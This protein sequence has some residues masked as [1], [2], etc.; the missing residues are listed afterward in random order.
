MLLNNIG[1]FLKKATGAGSSMLLHSATLFI[2]LKFIAIASG[3]SGVGL[4]SIVQ[5]HQNIFTGLASLS[6]GNAFTRDIAKNMSDDSPDLVLNLC[7]F[8]GLVLGGIL[9]VAAGVLWVLTYD[10]SN[11]ALAWFFAV[12]LAVFATANLNQITYSLRGLNRID[13]IMRIS[14]FNFF[15]ST[16]FFLIFYTL[17]F[18][19]VW[20]YFTIIPI[21]TIIVLTIIPEV[22]K[23]Y[24]KKILSISWLDLFA[25]LKKN[26]ISAL[27][28]SAIFVTVSQLT[29]RLIIGDRFGLTELGYFQ[30]AWMFSALVMMV[31][32]SI[33]SSVYLPAIS[34]PIKLEF[35]R[36]I[37]N[38]SR[39]ILLNLA[40]LGSAFIIFYFAGSYF[41]K[42]L[43]SDELLPAIP[44]VFA[45]FSI[46][47]IRCI[48]SPLGYF[49]F[50]KGDVVSFVGI[51]IIGGLV[52][53]IVLLFYIESSLV[54]VIF[55]SQGIAAVL[56]LLFILFRL[57]HNKI[58]LNKLRNING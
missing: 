49:A 5:A 34:N 29:Y 8:M 14:S 27:F 28:L 17:G 54:S 57:L 42:I 52:S 30:T 21:S 31:N 1:A 37:L 36:S 44:I 43:A 38:T 46:D 53:L 39:Q 56:A 3:A 58:F 2:R 47:A 51:D 4:L 26:N 35:N 22:R 13:C 25:Y 20:I 48:V 18:D 41:I 9:S 11:E 23:L 33:M 55:W 6:A 10:V 15:L 16:F 32:T 24:T 50:S 7:I 12:F 19:Q 45:L 40:I